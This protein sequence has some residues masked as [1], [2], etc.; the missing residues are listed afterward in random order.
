SGQKYAAIARCP[1]FT[2]TLIGYDDSAARKVPGVTAIVKIPGLQREGESR[3]LNNPGVA[4]VAESLWAAKTGRDALIVRWDAGPNADENDALIAARSATAIADSAQERNVLHEAGD[5]DSALADAPRRHRAT[6]SVPHFAHLNMEPLNCTASVTAD[7]C[8]LALSHQSV[9]H[10]A[11]F[12]ADH[13]GIP[14]EQV[15]VRVG[16]IGC[17]LGRKWNSD[18][19]FEALHLSQEVGAPVKVF[20]SRED[21]VEQDFLNPQARFE[22]DAGLSRDGRILAWHAVHSAQGGTRMRGFPAQLIADQRIENVRSEGNVRL[23]AWRGPGNNVSG[24]AVEGFLNELAHEADRDPLELRLELLG[25]DRELPFDE[26]MPMP[27]DTGI[28]TRKMKSVLRLAASQASW[29]D[30]LPAGWGRGIASHFTF[31][32]YVACVVDVTV[33]GAGEFTVERVF[34]GVDCGRVVNR[35]GAEAQI[36]SGIHD[37]LSTVVHQHARIEGGRITTNNFHHIRLLRMDK[38]PRQIRVEFVDSNEHPWGTG[39][40]ALPAFIP[41]LIAALHNATGKRIRRLPIADQLR[42]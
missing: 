5:V 16:R 10:A 9:S 40:I 15:E 35:L 33:D 29:G 20:W 11:M 30:P 28:S 36:E 22:F 7:R 31:G 1:Y 37:G 38:A 34:T 17:G 3:R 18:F 6:Y 12:A 39:E 25:E 42:A 4:V 21:D 41:A 23:G 2:G 14:V 26:W 13:L 32:S 24:F 8:I 27:L 19:I